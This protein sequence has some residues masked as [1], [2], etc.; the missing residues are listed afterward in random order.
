MHMPL[1]SEEWSAT[2]V[3]TRTYVFTIYISSIYQR[4]THTKKL[5]VR[6]NDTLSIISGCLKPT[7]K[8]LL[9]VLLG[10]AMNHLRRE[11]ST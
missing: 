8:E 10:I 1:T 3:N 7:C 5:D 11:P 2:W 6:S 9:Q 4:S